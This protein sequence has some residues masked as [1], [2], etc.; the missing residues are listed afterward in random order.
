[1]SVIGDQCDELRDRAGTL[2]ASAESIC[3]EVA[4]NTMAIAAEEM[5]EAAA[6]ISELRCKMEDMVDQCDEIERLKVENA[7][8]RE[9]VLDIWNDA[10]RFDGFWDYVYDD[11]TIYREDELPH[12]Q[13]RMRECGIEVK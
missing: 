11:G 4:R 12:Y 8:L 3:D 6:V 10:L 1:V 7:K 2:R 13:E 9:L 5:L